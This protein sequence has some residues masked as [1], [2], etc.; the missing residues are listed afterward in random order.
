[1]TSY[2]NE[3][4]TMPPKGEEEPEEEKLVNQPWGYYFHPN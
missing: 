2:G 3:I 4:D 1:M